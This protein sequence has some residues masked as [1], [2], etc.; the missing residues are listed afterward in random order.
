MPSVTEALACRAAADATPFELLEAMPGTAIFPPGFP[1]PVCEYD[2][3]VGRPRRPR[4]L[5]ERRLSRIEEELGP[6]EAEK[7]RLK[8]RASAAGAFHTAY[9]D[10]DGLVWRCSWCGEAGTIVE[11]RRL[12]LECPGWLLNL[13]DHADDSG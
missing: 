12:A 6:I 9:L 8:L 13:L 3:R 4:L 1:C 10:D 11:L 2:V 5:P 7:E